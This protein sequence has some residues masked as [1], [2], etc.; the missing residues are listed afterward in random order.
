MTLHFTNELDLILSQ[1][2]VCGLCGNYDGKV[3]NDFTTRNKE[4]AVEALDFGNSW[5]VSPKCSDAKPQKP[6]CSVYTYRR[7]WASKRC[8]IINSEVFAGCHSK[9]RKLLCHVAWNHK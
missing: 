3:K 5:K 4:V 8:S 1:G 2:K 9:V 7:A 6:S